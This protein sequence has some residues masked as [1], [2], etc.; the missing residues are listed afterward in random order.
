MVRR[1]VPAAAIG[2]GFDARIVKTHSEVR[3]RLQELDLSLQ[4]ERM[5][6]VV[7]PIQ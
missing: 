3:M 1:P 2:L 4:L 7:V 5:G 6:P